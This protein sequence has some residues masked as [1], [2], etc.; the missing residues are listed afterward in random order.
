MNK[1]NHA[2]TR[3]LELTN[4]ATAMTVSKFAEDGP[5]ALI[6]SL[7]GVTGALAI[8]ANVSSQGGGAPNK[9]NV[10][11]AALLAAEAF[12]PGK[13]TGETEEGFGIAKAQLELNIPV[14]QAAIANFEKLT[15]RTAKGVVV[16]AL[17][18][19]VEKAQSAAVIPLAD[20]IAKRNAAQKGTDS[21]N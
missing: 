13:E 14:Y 21:I 7:H 3:L 10:L 19:L 2:A 15:G 11:F 5:E 6:L 17:L 20:F 18:E 12:N 9:D 1:L 8:T 16:D 4:T